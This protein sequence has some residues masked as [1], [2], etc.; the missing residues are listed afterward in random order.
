MVGVTITEKNV[1]IHVSICFK[2]LKGGCRE[3]GLKE[4][5]PTQFPTTFEL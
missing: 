2:S 4:S 1:K 5:T 3:A